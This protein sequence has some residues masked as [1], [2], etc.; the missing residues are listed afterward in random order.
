MIPA[1]ARP[2]STQTSTAPITPKTT[3]H[4][5]AKAQA[6]RD[7]DEATRIARQQLREAE[8]MADATMAREAAA[9]S[10]SSSTE[11]SDAPTPEQIQ[12]QTTVRHYTM[13][14][15]VSESHSLNPPPDATHHS[16]YNFF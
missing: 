16:M 7:Q 8:D 5:D 2:T 6:K 9:G 10:N 13:G 11:D 15:M 4:D 3:A 1:P 14:N 12:A